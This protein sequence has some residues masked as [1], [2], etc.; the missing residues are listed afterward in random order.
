MSEHPQHHFPWRVTALVVAIVI[1]ATVIAG[2]ILTR[3]SVEEVSSPPSASASASQGPSPL[4]LD[5][6][7]QLTLLLQV[8]DKG[9]GIASSVL[10]AAAGN[11]G[12]VS[13]LLLPRD[14]LLPTSPPVRIK[15]TNGPRGPVSAQDPL[16]VLLGVQVDAA[17]DL[18]R[19]AW[20]GLIDAG[21]ALADPDKGE[22]A[23]AFPL[24]LDRVLKGLPQ[25]ESAIGQLLTS[26]GSMAPTSVTNEDASHLLHLIAEGLRQRPVKRAVLPVTYVRGGSRPVAVMRA[27]EAEPIL[28]DLFPKAMLQT[29]HPGSP[30][31]VLERSGASLGQVGQARESIVQA[32]MGVVIGATVGSGGRS[33]VY[34]PEESPAA[35][36]LGVDAAAALGLPETAVLVDSGANPVVDL[37]ITLGSDYA[38]V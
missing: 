7:R 5:E 34:I 10:I 23:S 15:D 8:H 28:A 30:R 21:G 27:A 37:R 31:V 13:E 9:S 2:V 22:S 26:L 24:V 35:R 6:R 14:L 25:D 4:P 11:T 17:I 29:G 16:Q 19:L 3:N 12:F 33:V 20:A 36:R 1:L 18:D 32:G 38:P